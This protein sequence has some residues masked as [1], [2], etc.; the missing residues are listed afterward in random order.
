MRAPARPSLILA[1]HPFTR[2]FGWVA[3]E[4]P[5][6]PHDWGTAAARK[7][8]N[9][10]CLRKLEKLFDRLNPE[11]FL[12]ETYEPQKSSRSARTARLCRAM[13]ALA[14]DRGL[15]VAVYRRGDVQGAFAHVG[16]KSRDEIAAAV[17]RHIDAFRNR[18]PKPR[19]KAWHR[20]QDGM[21]MFTAASL[22]LTH[23]QLGAST[24]FDN[25]S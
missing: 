16:A 11:T 14:V 20:E 2:G 18:L 6:A 3:F 9:A 1:V 24:L 13:V 12:L 17:A 15:E 22:V 4:G 10:V 19:E 25:L 5:F 7:D 8:K 21:A 23:F